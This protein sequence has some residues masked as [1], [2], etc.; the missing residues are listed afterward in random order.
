VVTSVAA[1]MALSGG[2]LVTP[3]Q[4]WALELKRRGSSEK[5][6]SPAPWP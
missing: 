6:L 2:M 1:G 5:D 4:V 3:G